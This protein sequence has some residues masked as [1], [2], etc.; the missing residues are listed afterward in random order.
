[1]GY[2]VDQCPAVILTTA[3]HIA[4]TQILAKL[5]PNAELDDM[6]KTQILKGYE[7][8]YKDHPAWMSEV[9]RYFPR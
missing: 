4:V 7:S 1:L 9:R 5:I 8:A 3:E 2:P 6:T